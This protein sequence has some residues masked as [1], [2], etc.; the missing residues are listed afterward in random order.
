MISQKGR[1]RVLAPTTKFRGYHQCQSRWRFDLLCV[2]YNKCTIYT[3]VSR[4]F[5]PKHLNLRVMVKLHSSGARRC[6]GLCI[7]PLIRGRW[8]ILF[9]GPAPSACSEFFILITMNRPTTGSES[10]TSN[11][12]STGFTGSRVNSMLGEI[13]TNNRLSTCF[14]ETVSHC[15]GCYDIRGH[16]ETSIMSLL[17]CDVT[18]L[19]RTTSHACHTLWRHS[20][21]T[22]V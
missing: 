5:M 19:S 3:S 2:I 9:I 15:I 18:R 4:Q 11:V 17:L 14:I 10:A 12:R 7:T 20:T 13:K 6:V 8:K 16:H 21:I 1:R 22:S